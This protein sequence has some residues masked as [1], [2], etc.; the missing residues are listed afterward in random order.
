MSRAPGFP[1]LRRL[2]SVF[3]FSLL[4]PLAASAID[5]DV[6]VEPGVA[7]PLSEPQSQHFDLGGAASLKGLVGFEHS[8]LS[9]AGGVTFIGLAAQSGYPNTSAGI[10][11]AP[12]FGIRIQRPRETLEE[13]DERMAIP[14]HDFFNGVRPWLDADILYVRTGG[15]DRAGFQAALGLAFPLGE[16]RAFWLGPFVRYFQ[17]FQDDQA[18]RDDRDAKILIIGLSLEVGARFVQPTRVPPPPP[19]PI[20]PEVVAVAAAPLPIS[21][22]DRDGDGTPDDIDACPDVQGPPTNAGCP[23]YERVI[24]KPDR[25]ELKEKIQFA[26]NSSEIDPVSHPLLDEVAKALQDI[27]GARV[28]IEGHASSEGP[29]ARNE[30]LS[31]ERAQSVLNYLAKHGVARERLSSKGFSSSRPIETNATESGREANRRVDFVVHFLILKE[32]SPQ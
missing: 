18:N 24:V 27:K 21:K 29:E 9:L 6:K 28:A 23:V 5:L 10:A 11:W 15:L 17:I 14:Q 25:L 12:S 20:C 22:P 31:T 13:R 32:E 3:F 8:Y 30:K 26:D 19:A 1:P 16:K 2:A 4:T 7:L